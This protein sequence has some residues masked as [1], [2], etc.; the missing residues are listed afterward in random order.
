MKNIEIIEGIS[1]KNKNYIVRI[2]TPSTKKDWLLALE[3]SKVLAEK[4][5]KAGANIFRA[6]PLIV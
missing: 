1:N 3:Y 4:I 6:V 2:L 5:T